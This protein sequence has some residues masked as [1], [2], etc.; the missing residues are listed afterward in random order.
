[1]LP[2]AGLAAL[3][4]ALSNGA[5]LVLVT[6]PT[7]SSKTTTLYAALGSLDAGS[8]KIL[9]AEDPVEY[10]LPGITQVNINDRIGLGFS[11]VLRAALRQDPDAL[12]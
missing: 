11:Q 8:T 6:G 4:E 9:T 3:R 10:R 12:L 7:G 5:G 1:G 2:A